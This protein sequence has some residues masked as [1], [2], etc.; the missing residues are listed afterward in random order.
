MPII[1]SKKYPENERFISVKSW[2]K[3]V[4]SGRAKHFIIADD[5]DMQDT[6]IAAPSSFTDFSKPPKETNKEMNREDLKKWLDEHEI[7]Y[8]I[9]TSTPKLYKLYLENQ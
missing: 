7:E 4:E 8:N 5:G 9:R 1:Q 6:V 3:W 2:T